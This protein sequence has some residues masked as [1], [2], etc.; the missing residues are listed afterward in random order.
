[1]S[2]RVKAGHSAAIARPLK[3]ERL[4]GYGIPNLESINFWGTFPKA[5]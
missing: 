3:K 1:M 5:I 4:R 2:E